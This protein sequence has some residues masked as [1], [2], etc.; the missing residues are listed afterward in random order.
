MNP[1]RKRA[2]ASAPAKVILF[3]EHFVVYG[4]PAILASIDRRVH[5]DAAT[6]K[7]EK[8]RVRSNMGFSGSFSRDEVE[9]VRKQRR[10][11][12][13][14]QPV[15]AAASDAMREFDAHAGLDIQIRAEVP[16]AMGLGSSAATSIATIAAVGTLFGKMGRERICDLSLEAERIV[17]SN[18]SGADSAICTYGGLMLFKRDDGARPIRSSL[19]LRLVVVSS[20]V[21]RVTGRLVSNVKNL[22]E[23][24]PELFSGLS[25]MSGNLTGR[26]L[27]AIKSKDYAELGSLMTL[28]HSLL[29]RLGVSRRILDRLVSITL[30]AGALGAKMTG[31]GGGGCIIGL[32]TEGS[33]KKVLRRVSGGYDAFLSRVDRRGVV[34]ESMK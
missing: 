13:M 31:A 18:P 6:R 14:V 22:R 1:A 34:V 30:D 24:D 25:G 32:V 27:K 5:V 8:I 17:H 10:F 26:A 20:G 16:Y 28:N 23:S 3:G 15:L 21:R 4:M 7:D 19:D 12:S 33:K 2:R 11:R 9:K 29:R